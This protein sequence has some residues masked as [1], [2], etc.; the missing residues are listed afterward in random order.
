M[1]AT[2]EFPSLRNNLLLAMP[3]VSD[4]IFAH[5]VTLLCEHSVQGAMGI[6][7]NRPLDI[8]W[9][10]I[11]EQLDINIS[12]QQDQRVLA[13]GPVQMGQGFVLHPNTDQHWANSTAISSEAVLTTSMDI[14]NAL[15]LGEGPPN[16]IMALGYAGW[17]AGQLEDEL[18]RNIWLTLPADQQILFDVP[19]HLKA[20][21]A[22]RKLGINL[23][24]VSPVVG[25]A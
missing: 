17:N 16:S 21:A 24:L 6:I 3:G 14:I 12:E 18:S 7:I 4:P 23:N 15:A 13:G 2:T 25:H 8:S 20:D 11:F 9:R 22:A 19:L 10:D 1:S 5:S